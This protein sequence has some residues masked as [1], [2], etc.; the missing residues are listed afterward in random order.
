MIKEFKCIVFKYLLI[1]IILLPF[2][3]VGCYLFY[4]AMRYGG[5]K[6]VVIFLLIIILATI[7]GIVSGYL[8]TRR[9]LE[10]EV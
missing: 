6:A 10:S 7:I 8:F 5:L 1:I 9:L 4:R 2:V 3:I